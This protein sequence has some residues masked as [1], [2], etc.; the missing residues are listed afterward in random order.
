MADFDYDIVFVGRGYSIATYLYMADLQW[1]KKICIIG[2]VDAWQNVVRGDAGIVNH[3]VYMYGRSL[4]DRRSQSQNPTE[5][6]VLVSD[7]EKIIADWKQRLKKAGKQVDDIPALVTTISTE[8]ITLT[9]PLERRSEDGTVVFKKDIGASITVNKLEYVEFNRPISVGYPP[10]KLPITV[11]ALKIVYGGGAGPHTVPD[12][13]QELLIKEGRYSKKDNDIYITVPFLDAFPE[14]GILDL[15]SFM[16][17]CGNL[18]KDG[19][20]GKTVALMGPNAGIDAAI[21]AL[22]YGFTLNYLLRTN[23]KPFWLA[24]KHY[25]IDKSTKGDQAIKAVEDCIIKYKSSGRGGLTVDQN[26]KSYKITYTEPN[27]SEKNINVDFIVYATGQDPKSQEILLYPLD[28][29]VLGERVTRIG[30]ARVLLPIVEKVK[31]KAINDVNQRFG[32]RESTAL[33]LQLDGTDKYLGLEVIGA[34]AFALARANDG[35]RHWPTPLYVEKTDPPIDKQMLNLV[36]QL[37]QAPQV[38]ADQLG[39][40]RSQIEG[41]TGFDIRGNADDGNGLSNCALSFVRFAGF[42]ENPDKA[43][44]ILT[45]L[46]LFLKCSTIELMKSTQIFKGI[47]QNTIKEL[48]GEEESRRFGQCC[49][50]VI[51]NMLH[52][53]T[54]THKDN[55]SNFEIKDLQAFLPTARANVTDLLGFMEIIV[56]EKTVDF[57]GMDQTGI[58]V[59]LAGRYPRLDPDNWPMIENL[60]IGGRRISP[61]GYDPV[62]TQ[63]IQEWLQILNDMP[64]VYFFNQAELPLCE[65]FVAA[66]YPTIDQSLITQI[67]NEIVFNRKGGYDPS[68]LKLIQDWLEKIN[69]MV[70]GIKPNIKPDIGNQTSLAK[71]FPQ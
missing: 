63:A 47:Y 7:N 6:Q 56:G 70:T 30:A 1:A 29:R 17:L 32:S 51:E 69:S 59:L 23:D 45:V 18:E 9:E 53:E 8:P 27:D 3:A 42:F 48:V 40:I 16:R 65:I 24:T 43:P 60:I 20:K 39:V 2:G 22:Q 12:F 10:E 19:D 11:T 46:R 67:S 28:K 44:F 49:D 61:Y 62:H 57:N 5:R 21:A 4:E 26:K 58:A 38:T 55:E 33:G 41:I 31:L 14:S 71:K 13:L 34:A 64:G 50:Q 54:V 36:K 68:Q 37:N 66:K 52:I 25:E 15:D 35:N